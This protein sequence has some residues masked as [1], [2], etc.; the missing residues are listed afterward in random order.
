M[1]I[2]LVSAVLFC[3]PLLLAA[4]LMNLALYFVYVHLL[5]MTVT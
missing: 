4:Q 2:Y 3:V 5:V 1:A